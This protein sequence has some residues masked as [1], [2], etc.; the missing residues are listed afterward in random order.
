MM[1]VDCIWWYRR[2]AVGSNTDTPQSWKEK[3]RRSSLGAAG[4]KQ[5]QTKVC[6]SHKEHHCPNKCL[7]RKERYVFHQNLN[8]E[9]NTFAIPLNSNKML[10]NS[11]MRVIIPVLFRNTEVTLET[12][13]RRENDWLLGW[14]SRVAESLLVSLSYSDQRHTCMM[15]WTVSQHYLLNPIFFL[16]NVSV[17]ATRFRAICYSV[18]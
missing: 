16:Q 1:S 14:G 12:Y 10:F 2:H 9:S 11:V 13:K 17:P 6:C 18:L 3:K 7:D 8:I 4:A 5:S 15:V